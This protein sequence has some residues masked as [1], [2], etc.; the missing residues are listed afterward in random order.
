MS[1]TDE[2]RRSSSDAVV[3][4]EAEVSQ[5]ADDLVNS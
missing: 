2:D 1:S 3:D 4:E 5:R